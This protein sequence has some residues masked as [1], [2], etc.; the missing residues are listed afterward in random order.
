MYYCIDFVQ[1][2]GMILKN[3]IFFLILDLSF[4][5][6]ELDFTYIVSMSAGYG[7]LYSYFFK[8]NKAVQLYIGLSD[9]KKF[10]K[11]KNFD[12]TNKKWNKYSIMHYLYLQSICIFILLGSNVFKGKSCRDENEKKNIHEVCGLFTYTWLPFNI[13]FFPVKQ[14]YLVLQLFGVNYVYMVAGLASWMVVETVEHLATRI[15]HV[16]FLF[17]QALEQKN[18]RKK[19]QMFNH[20]VQYH[21]FVFG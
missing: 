15:R 6:T 20:A 21:V 3:M 7:L 14:L 19:R 13:D 10:G 1:L 12:E 9:F 4:N 16:S 8:V 5:H 2:L 18:L 17:T 11:P